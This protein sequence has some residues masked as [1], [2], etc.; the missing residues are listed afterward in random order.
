MKIG[1]FGTG[2]VGRTLASKLV[3]LGHDVR[4]GS[5]TAANPAAGEWAEAEGERASCGTFQAAAASADFLF[6]CT[7]GQVSLAVLSSIPGDTLVG[8][9]LVDVANPLDFSGGFP[10]SLSVVNTDS[11]GEQIQRALPET[12]VV[13]A[14]NTLSVDVTV[15][16]GQLGAR[17]DIF[18]AGNDGDAKQQVRSLL[19]AFGWRSDDVHDLGG[20]TAARATEMYLP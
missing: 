15:D 4:L 20:I 11:L 10:P 7:P 17:H 19:V 12:C 16:P 18:I 5:R 8:K 13:K 14:L 2:V 1:V 3:S 9:V 6:N